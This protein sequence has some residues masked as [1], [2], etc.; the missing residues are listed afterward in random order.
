LP[1][2]NG[3]PLY[4]LLAYLINKGK[5][6]FNILRVKNK[7]EMKYIYI[8]QMVQPDIYN[9]QCYVMFSHYE[10]T[11]LEYYVFDQGYKFSWM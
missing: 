7:W 8:I 11:T 10:K 5:I 4:N 2:G 3:G 9:N 1:E 6:D